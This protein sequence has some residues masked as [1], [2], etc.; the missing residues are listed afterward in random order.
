[1]IEKNSKE[2]GVMNMIHRAVMM[3]CD[4]ACVNAL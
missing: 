1:M 4:T 3:M 2:G